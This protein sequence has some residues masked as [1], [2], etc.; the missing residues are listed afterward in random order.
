MADESFDVDFYK[1]YKKE[2]TTIYKGKAIVTNL[3][4]RTIELSVEGIEGTYYSKPFTPTQARDLIE[5]ASAYPGNSYMLY[6]T[7][8]TFGIKHSDLTRLFEQLDILPKDMK[9]DA[10]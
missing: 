5:R 4:W 1:P 10:T 9:T 6:T 2:D 3:P 8:G 7:E